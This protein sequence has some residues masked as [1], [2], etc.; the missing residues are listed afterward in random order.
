MKNIYLVGMMGSGKTSTARELAEL[1]DLPMIDLD[2]ELEKQENK[3]IAEIFQGRGE[4]W[5][6]EREAEILVAQSKQENFVVATGG[7]VVIR[8]QNRELMKTTGTVVF[9][10]AS[11]EQLWA[12]VSKEKGRPLLEDFD[13][14]RK[15][16]DLMSARRPFYEDCV[17]LRVMTD[18]KTPKQV[19]EEIYGKLNAND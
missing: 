4:E 10:E 8:R 2:A 12:R 6:R 11:L 14:K 15:L 19:A 1:L 13:P 18:G 7:G 3:C 17:E 5:F 16:M 9:L